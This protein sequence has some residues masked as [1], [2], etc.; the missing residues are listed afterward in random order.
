MFMPLSLYIK[1]T[2]NY[3]FNLTATL[4]KNNDFRWVYDWI[5]VQILNV[6]LKP[7]LT[8]WGVKI[9]LEEVELF[10]M[11]FHKLTAKWMVG[12]SIQRIN[13]CILWFPGHVIYDRK[14]IPKK[15]LPP[16]FG[17][18]PSRCGTGEVWALSVFGCRCHHHHQFTTKKCYSLPSNKSNGAVLRSFRA[19]IKKLNKKKKKKRAIPPSCSN[20]CNVKKKINLGVGLLL[21]VS[22]RRVRR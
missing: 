18:C 22:C 19:V 10:S 8:S 12:T 14:Y 6:Q 2:A 15:L 17:T 5:K 7:L 16:S 21:I 1:Q 3:S 13:K 11:C 20:D 9:G 4:A